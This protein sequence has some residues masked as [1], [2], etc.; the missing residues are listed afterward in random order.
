MLPLLVRITNTQTGETEHSAFPSSPVRIGRNQLNELV[1]NE[2]FVSQWHAVVRFDEHKVRY[3]DLGST[4]GTM[5]NG[6]RLARHMQVE[7]DP[8]SDL[9]IGP[10]QL[11]F[12]RAQVTPDMYAAPRTTIFNLN[13]LG[14]GGGDGMNATMAFNPNEPATEQQNT[15]FMPQG[16]PPGAAPQQPAAGAAVDMQRLLAIT[17]AAKP[18]YQQ[19][20]SAWAQVLSALKRQLEAAPGP[21]RAGLVLSLCQQFPQLAKEPEFRQLADSL[22]VDPAALGEV[23]ASAWIE[24]LGGS[25]PP[26]GQQINTALAMERVGAI[27]ESYSQAFVELRKGYEQFGEEMAL[28]LVQE[29]TPLRDAQSGQEVLDYLLDWSTD[30]GERVRELTRAFADLALHQV[31]L[32]SG[33]ME[34]VRSLLSSVSPQQLS[35]QKN[36]ALARSGGGGLL[37]GIFNGKKA[38]LWKAFADAHQRLTEEDRFSREVFGRNFARAYF[39]VT[40]GHMQGQDGSQPGQTGQQPTYGHPHTSPYNQ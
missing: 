38:S 39:M 1:L 29:R 22:G 2:P 27:L 28:Q 26:A 8:Q 9:R 3:V 20:R 6:R 21:Q 14:G 34:G 18:F 16:V 40:G 23:D 35:G 32:L 10:I 33:V 24:R 37:E 30:G 13:T 4:N 12:A 19:Y 17:E 7:I 11:A 36:Y 31:A 25:K 15:L 5:L